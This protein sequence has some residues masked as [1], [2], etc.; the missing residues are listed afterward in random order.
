MELMKLTLFESFCLV[1]FLMDW[2][3]QTRWEAL[4]KSKNWVALFV[5]SLVYTLGFL[6]LFFFY[7]VNFW[8]LG[9]IFLTHFILDRR[10]LEIWIMN[11]KG[12]KKELLPEPL[13]MITLLG[14]DQTL[15]I[16]V[17][18]IIVMIS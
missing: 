5:H 7:K 9:I 1:H 15:H 8:F 3:F 10:D 11:L 14:L 2:I 13:W 4:N 17:L 18:A 12:S 16:L 6:P